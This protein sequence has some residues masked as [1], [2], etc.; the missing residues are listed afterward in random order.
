MLNML[1]MQNMCIFTQPGAWLCPGTNMQNMQ[2]ILSICM[3]CIFCI[4]V[5]L[6]CTE[7][8]TSGHSASEEIQHHPGPHL[9]L[10]H[11]SDW[12]YKTSG[13]DAHFFMAICTQEI[14]AIQ[15]RGLCV[16]LAA[17]HLWRSVS[18]EDQQYMVLQV[19]SSF[20]NRYDDQCG[21]ENTLLCL[22]FCAGGIPRSLEIRLYCAFSVYSAYSAYSCYD[23][24]WLLSSLVGCVPVHHRILA[25]WI[26][27]SIAC[28]SSV[29]HTGRAASCSSPQYR[30]DAVRDAKRSSQISRRFLPQNNGRQR[31][32]QVVVR[33]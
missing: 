26:S 2:N 11:S 10:L 12:A 4:F 20:L 27:A 13:C 3:L 5:D 9:S 19:A 28:D 32:L 17:R 21:N 18:A 16:H 25:L 6:W 8:G 15:S 29:L 33:E 7:Q 31:R 22:C 14:A 23:F 30:D 24:V 1:N